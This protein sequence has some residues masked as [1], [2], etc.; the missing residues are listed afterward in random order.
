[1]KSV[2]TTLCKGQPTRWPQYIKKCQRI[3]NREIHEATGEQP[4]FLMFNRRASRLIGAELPQIGQDSDLEVALDVVRRNNIKQARKWRDRANIGKK[5]RRV[6]ER[7]LVWV[8][9]DYTTSV[10]DRKLGVKGIGPYKVKKVLKQ[11]GAY[12][13]ENVF[14]GVLVQRAADKVK[15]YVERGVLVQPQEVFCQ[16]NSKQEEEVEPRTVGEH[17]PPRRYGEEKEKE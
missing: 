6:E 16:E 17:R 2:L 1:M 3:H 5:N 8:R 9:K 13:L 15:P 10:N 14:D 7:K 11:G 4:Y 12:R